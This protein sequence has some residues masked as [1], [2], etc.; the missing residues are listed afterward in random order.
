MSIVQTATTF[1][2]VPADRPERFE[3]ALA[4]GAGLVIVDLEDAVAPEHREAGRDAIAAASPQLRARVAVRINPLGSAESARDVELLAGS[5]GVAAVVVT[6]AEDPAALTGL[7]R[8]LGEVPLI[9][10]VE[11][12]AGIARVREI[13]AAEGVA[14]LAFGHLDYA[15]DL[16]VEPVGAIITHAR[17]ELVVASRAAGLATAVDG[18][19]TE[20]DDLEVAATDARAAVALGFGAKLCIHPKQVPVV[21][22]AFRPSEAQLEWARGIIEVAGGASRVGSQMVDGP[23]VRRA[24]ALLEA[25]AR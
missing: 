20:L 12:A 4:A 24:R 3:K 10:L 25:A 7:W 11:T 22:A 6:K 15:S 16:G 21:A 17:C 1:L 18:V 13:A 8:S 19:T 14:R 23:L 2:F 9:A 5:S